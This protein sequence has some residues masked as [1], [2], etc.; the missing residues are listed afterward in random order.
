LWWD[1]S[2]HSALVVR[3]LI[4]DK[5]WALLFLVSLTRC[6]PKSSQ[7]SLWAGIREQYPSPLWRALALWIEAS[8]EWRRHAKPDYEHQQHTTCLHASATHGAS[9]AIHGDTRGRGTKQRAS[10]EQIQQLTYSQANWCFCWCEREKQGERRELGSHTSNKL[11]T[12][13]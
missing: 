10:L 11:G 13:A 5:E 1:C 8:H 6:S 12:E 7:A 9:L 2:Q 4:E 3:L